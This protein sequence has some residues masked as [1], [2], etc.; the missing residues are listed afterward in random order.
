MIV[1]TRIVGLKL[2][3]I[4]LIVERHV[5]TISRIINNYYEHGSVE[6]PKRSGR[7]KKLSDCNRKNLVREMKQ[8]CHASLAEIGNILSIVFV[9]KLWQKR[10]M[11][12]H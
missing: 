9:C 11:T 8:N 4:A 5:L 1:G 3:E 12:L 6:L 7:T 10:C 2:S